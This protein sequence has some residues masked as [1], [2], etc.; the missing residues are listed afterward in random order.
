[1][2]T[3][4][5]SLQQARTSVPTQNGPGLQ[6]S[7]AEARTSGYCGTR[8]A[9]PCCSRITIPTKN[10]LSNS[11]QGTAELPGRLYFTAPHHCQWARAPPMARIPS[12]IC[13]AHYATT[14]L[15]SCI[16][17]H[18]ILSRSHL[19]THTP[20]PYSTHSRMESSPPQPTTSPH[21]WTLSTISADSRD[22]KQQYEGEKVPGRPLTKG[23]ATAEEATLILYTFIHKDSFSFSHHAYRARWAGRNPRPHQRCIAMYIYAELNNR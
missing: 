15:T 9:V 16:H 12:N 23:E 20:A 17:I 11:L 22:S 8:R 14:L 5:P 18:T 2:Q 13:T 10:P 21:L 3:P 1:M 7:L 6:T 19:H 4:P